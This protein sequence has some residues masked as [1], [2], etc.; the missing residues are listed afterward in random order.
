MVSVRPEPLGLPNSGDEPLLQYGKSVLKS[1]HLFGSGYPM[2]PVGR[3]LDEM[4]AL[5]LDDEVRDRWLYANA[6]EFLTGRKEP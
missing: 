6:Q 4:K 2:M 3:S 5:P 1:R